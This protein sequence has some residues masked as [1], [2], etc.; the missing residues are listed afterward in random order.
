MFQ[1]D[2][3]VDRCIATFLPCL[4]QTEELAV[5]VSHSPED[6]LT[7]VAWHRDGTKFVAGGARGQFYQCNLEVSKPVA[8]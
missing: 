4:F 7:A 6:S 5:K 2:E 1:L 8:L 3:H